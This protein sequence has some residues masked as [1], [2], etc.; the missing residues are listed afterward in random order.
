MPAR[1][2]EPVCYAHLFEGLW[3]RR[4]ETRCARGGQGTDAGHTAG[5]LTLQ[6]KRHCTRLLAGSSRRSGL[7]STVC[8]R[9]PRIASPFA[10]LSRIRGNS[11]L[12]QSGEFCVDAR[13]TLE[14][15]GSEI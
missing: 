5:E 6:R 14:A 15:G 7:R 8:W 13:R 4:P 9:N 1:A 11:V 12:A 2:T 10:T 3:A